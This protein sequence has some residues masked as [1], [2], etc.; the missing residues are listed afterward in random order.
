MDFCQKHDSNTMTEIDGFYVCSACG[1]VDTTMVI[2]ENKFGTYQDN[3]NGSNDCYLND[4]LNLNYSFVKHTKRINRLPA[5]IETTSS[6]TFSPHPLPSQPPPNP[7]PP[8]PPPPTRTPQ[9]PIKKIFNKQDQKI[10]KLISVFNIFKNVVNKLNIP[11]KYCFLAQ[12]LYRRWESKCTNS[13]RCLLVPLALYMSFRDDV[14]CYVTKVEILNEFAI[15]KATAFD[16]LSYALINA[17]KEQKKSKDNQTSLFTNE[18]YTIIHENEIKKNFDRINVFIKTL[19][20]LASSQTTPSR[21][22]SSNSSSSDV[23][24]IKNC[25]NDE[26]QIVLAL[27]PFKKLMALMYTDSRLVNT[28]FV[29]KLFLATHIQINIKNNIN[30]S[31]CM[32]SKLIKFF[33]LQSTTA[34]V[35]INIIYNS[36][37]LDDVKKILTMA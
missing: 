8:N 22:T 3:W 20:P 21:S 26:K 5:T 31:K 19:H 34:K 10:K 28:S 27:I 30:I 1:F 23:C 37:S 24:N 13:Q 36:S 32:L 15:T 29:S 17:E 7:P 2:L 16:R 9:Q 6:P 18:E 33:K 11:T 14:E 35:L 12:E 4:I 25:S